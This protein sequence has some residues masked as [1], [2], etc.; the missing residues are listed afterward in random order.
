[1]A[2][3]KTSVLSMVVWEDVQSV[4]KKIWATSHLRA[5]DVVHHIVMRKAA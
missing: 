5:V 3:F 1:M 2:H 4:I